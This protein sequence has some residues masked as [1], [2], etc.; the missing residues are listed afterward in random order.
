MASVPQ[1]PSLHGPA[2]CSQEAP[3]SQKPEGPRAIRE[4]RT[5]GRSHGSQR[6]C[7]AG[8]SA[9]NLLESNLLSPEGG[10]NPPV[11]PDA[12]VPVEPPRP[13]K[14]APDLSSERGA[15]L[16][17]GPSSLS[18]FYLHGVIWSGRAKG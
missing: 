3:G 15:A 10:I 5:Q 12:A 9:W 2:K 18:N 16:R 4:T 11:S 14:V 13:R 6:N 1:A 17:Q 7:W 8:T